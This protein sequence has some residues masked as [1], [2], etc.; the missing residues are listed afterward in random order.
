MKLYFIIR[1]TQKKNNFKQFNPTFSL[2]PSIACICSFNKFASITTCNASLTSKS[3]SHNVPIVVTK[4]I[5][6]DGFST[7]KNKFKVI[8]ISS[9]EDSLTLTSCDFELHT[10]WLRGTWNT[11]IQL[12]FS[13]AGSASSFEIKHP[14]VTKSH[15]CQPCWVRLAAGKS[16][17]ESY[18]GIIPPQEPL[19]W[20]QWYQM[21]SCRLGAN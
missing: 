12:L 8:F 5:L 7:N 2:P 1:R 17:A 20:T 14:G 13:V 6:W 9:T 19:R 16:K 15:F 4:I 21:R 18:T 10:W 3:S 11:I